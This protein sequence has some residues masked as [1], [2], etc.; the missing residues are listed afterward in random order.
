MSKKII[1]SVVL[2]III[3]GGLYYGLVFTERQ[4]SESDILNKA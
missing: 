3:V 4:E 2:A 1:I